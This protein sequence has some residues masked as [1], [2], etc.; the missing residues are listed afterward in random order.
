M[1]A[2]ERIMRARNATGGYVRVVV[3]ELTMRVQIA[4]SAGQTA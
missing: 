2:A 3:G 1:G 4:T